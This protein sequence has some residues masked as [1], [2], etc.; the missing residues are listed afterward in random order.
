M[1]TD[2]LEQFARDLAEVHRPHM[3]RDPF[4]VN[5]DLYLVGCR[6]CDG[7]RRKAV[8]PGS[9]PIPECTFW[10]RAKALGLVEDSPS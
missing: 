9:D 5:G 6:A 3:E 7:S 1:S 2:D 4:A 10:I 8:L